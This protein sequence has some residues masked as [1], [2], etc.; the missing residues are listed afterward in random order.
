MSGRFIKVDGVRLRQIRQ[1][2]A[3]SLRDLSESSGV[4]HDTINKL[5]TGK[6]EAQPRTIRSLAET[7]GVEPRELMEVR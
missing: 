5:E 3:L 4:A 2:Q 7:L 1:E 6:R